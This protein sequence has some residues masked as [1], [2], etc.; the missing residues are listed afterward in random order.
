MK[1]LIHRMVFGKRC[2][3]IEKIDWTKKPG[4]RVVTPPET[5]TESQFWARVSKLAEARKKL[6]KVS[7]EHLIFN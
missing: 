3:A 5:L 1:K 6:A 2:P 4:T 7:P